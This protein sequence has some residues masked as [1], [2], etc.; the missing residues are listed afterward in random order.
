MNSLTQVIGGF[1]IMDVKHFYNDDYTFA[2][3]KEDILMT[4]KEMSIVE[5]IE[6]GNA[7]EGLQK[8]CGHKRSCSP[9]GWFEY[10]F[11]AFR[12]KIMIDSHLFYFMYKRPEDT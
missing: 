9:L 11:S 5:L 6:A 7:P 4:K 3:E 1:T 10:R 12:F 2:D 8:V